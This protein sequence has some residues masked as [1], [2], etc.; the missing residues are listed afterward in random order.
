MK[1]FFSGLGS[2]S[3]FLKQSSKYCTEKECV[4]LCLRFQCNPVS[5]LFL[6]K[7]QWLQGVQLVE[8]MCDI[9]P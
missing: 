7:V 9:T 3:L 2:E 6:P 4:D 1:T 8:L 5:H